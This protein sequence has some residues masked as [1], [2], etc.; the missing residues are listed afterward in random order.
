MN[1]ILNYCEFKINTY[2]FDDISDDIIS[3]IITGYDKEEAMLA[4]CARCCFHSIS[5]ENK[6]DSIDYFYNLINNIARI[7]GYDY[8]DDELKIYKAYILPSDYK[9]FV[10]EEGLSGIIKLYEDVDSIIASGGETL[11]YMQEFVRYRLLLI[12]SEHIDEYYNK[13]QNL[14]TRLKKN[15]DRYNELKESVFNKIQ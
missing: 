1:D 13:M 14:L 3:G 7:S 8:Y 9:N 2:N 4:V 10:D 5:E 11:L 15:K 12:Y 6:P